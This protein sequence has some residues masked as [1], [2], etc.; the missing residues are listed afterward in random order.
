MEI[1]TGN[2]P[3][4]LDEEDRRRLTARRRRRIIAESEAEG[5]RGFSGRDSIKIFNEFYSAY[6]RKDKLIT[7]AVVYNFFTRVHK[8][9]GD[10]LPIGFLDS[11]VRMYDYTVLQEVKESLYYYNEERISRDIQNYLFAVNFE[12]GAVQTCT[13]TGE[14]LEIGEEFFQGIETRLL[15][16]EAARGQ[17]LGFRRETQKEYTADTLTR[18]M[19]A[20]G[21]PI[22]Q[23]RLYQS[24]HE[25]YV[26]NLKDK[27]LDPFLG[28][29]NFRRAIKDYDSREAF[30]TYDKKIRADVSFLMNNLMKNFHYTRQ[31]AKDVCIYV[32]DSNLARKFVTG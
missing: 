30:K 26:H 12:P 7:M 31:G 14:K 15:G 17:R 10:S 11:L 9:L 13:F 5:E 21:K 4:W 16:A 24:M 22:T 23:T 25:R 18:E 32:I 3:K 27:V 2:I 8:E 6:A 28:N 20:E 29:E 19:M 1:Y